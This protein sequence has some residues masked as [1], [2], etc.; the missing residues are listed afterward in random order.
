MNAETLPKQ[1]SA[2]YLILPLLAMAGVNIIWGV[3][4]PVTKPALE[5]I[6]PFTFAL[7]RFIVAM[8]ILIPLA[9]RQ[10]IAA[11]RGPDRKTLAIM[12]LM[13]FCIAQ[14]AQT[15]AL[16]MSPASD[17]SLISTSGPLWIA[18]MAS[19][20]LGEK[21]TKRVIGGFALA[22][23][24]LLLI[25]WPSGSS[26][27]ALG[28]RIIGNIIFLVNGFTWAYYNVMGKRMMDRYSPLVATT[29]AGIVGTICLVPFAIGELISGQT[30]V[31]SLAGIGGVLYTGLLVTVVGFLTLY[32]AYSR[33]RAAQVAITM[34]L[35][36]LAGVL[37]SWAMLGEQL[38]QFF[39]V[40]AI[41]VFA[42]V[43]LVSSGQNEG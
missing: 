16:T 39:I 28:P 32:W 21:L 23:I 12:G 26:E 34:Y 43:W 17:I 9:G 15:V 41:M 19:L 2:K 1:A 6:P 31:W 8:L 27:A 37:V 35:Q 40:G 29:A 14:L 13:G 42:A 5:S 24:G 25:M 30:I 20:W 7:L 38:N 18:L 4:F 22:I 11:L 36:P 10:A 3:A 33:V